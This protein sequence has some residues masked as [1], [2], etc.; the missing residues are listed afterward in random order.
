MVNATV[1]KE[2]KH[3]KIDEVFV[4]PIL[5]GAV[6]QEGALNPYEPRNLINFQL[7]LQIPRLVIQIQIMKTLGGFLKLRQCLCDRCYKGRCFM[8]LRN[9]EQQQRAV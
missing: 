7:P 9:A 2:G 5:C 4:Q 1:G 6:D 8:V 3:V